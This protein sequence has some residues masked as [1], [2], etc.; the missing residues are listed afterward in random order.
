MDATS[1][2]PIPFPPLNSWSP[3]ISLPLLCLAALFLMV[4]ST[5]FIREHVKTRSSWPA[6]E[7]DL[8]RFK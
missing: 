7:G 8:G 4:I 6:L 2:S 1:H 5:V 3:A